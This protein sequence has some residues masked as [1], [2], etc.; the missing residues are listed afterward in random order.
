MKIVKKCENC[1]TEFEY[2]PFILGGREFFERK[3]CLKCQLEY[4]KETDRL[5]EE[6]QEKER[7]RSK[8][9]VPPKPSWESICPPFYR[10]TNSQQ[11]NPKL[12]ELVEKWTMEKG[13]GFIGKPGIGKTRSA[14][15]ALKKAFEQGK[16]CFYTTSTQFFKA[17][18]DQF[19]VDDQQRR[20][21]KN[22]INK[23]HSSQ[24]ILLDDLG[25]GKFTGRTELE[26]FELL[27][28]RTSNN[29]PTLWTSNYSF[30]ELSKVISQDKSQPIIRRLSEFSKIIKI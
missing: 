16:S 3:L 4:D 19:S 24:V 14:F 12:V 20:E 13:L 30:E 26:L 7:L 23:L 8:K 2:E 5:W 6:R 11:L 1:S 29:F 27:E 28:Y 18:S 15:L 9:K 25:K 21:S 17:C 22:L 10:N